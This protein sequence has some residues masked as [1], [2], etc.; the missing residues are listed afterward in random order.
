MLTFSSGSPQS[1]TQQ[2]TENWVSPFSVQALLLL[3]N[4]CI[5]WA[6][7]AA[8]GQA[9]PTAFHPFP[10]RS[11]RDEIWHEEDSALRQGIAENTFNV[12]PH[13]SFHKRGNI[14]G[15]CASSQSLNR[16]LWKMGQSKL[17]FLSCSSALLPTVCISTD[18]SGFEITWYQVVCFVAYLETPRISF[19]GPGTWSVPPEPT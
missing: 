18:F 2:T 17:P 16:P 6:A 7:I 19:P 5:S 8:A 12:L 13:V 14:D 10:S 3:C 9:L 4:P 11:E 1:D 15:P